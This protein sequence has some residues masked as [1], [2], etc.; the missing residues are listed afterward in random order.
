MNSGIKPDSLASGHFDWNCRGLWSCRYQVST[1]I[2]TMF[3]QKKHFVILETHFKWKVCDFSPSLILDVATLLQLNHKLLSST[4]ILPIYRKLEGSSY[5]VII[6]L[7]NEINNRLDSTLTTS[8]STMTESV[9]YNCFH[10]IGWSLA[11]AWVVFSCVHGYGGKGIFKHLAILFGPF[12]FLP[13]TPT[14]ERQVL[15]EQP[16]TYKTK[17]FPWILWVK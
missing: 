2:N 1:F 11:L 10:K 13:H 12:H 3:C 16:R 9:F 4:Y 5:V 6:K 14:L 8:G 15:F 17:C 7:F